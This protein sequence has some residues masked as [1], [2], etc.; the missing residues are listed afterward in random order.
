MGG[1][2][3]GASP[4][5]QGGGQATASGATT[6][7]GLVQGASPTTGTGTNVAGIQ[8]PGANA[9]PG[10]PPGL[11]GTGVM[12]G[13]AIPLAGMGPGGMGGHGLAGQP[14]MVGLMR[15][16]GEYSH[17]ELPRQAWGCAPWTGLDHSAIT[18]A[19]ELKSVVL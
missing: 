4:G 2:V 7:G 1:L 5:N 10:M 9:P 3:Q 13:T 14:A 8:G 12:P 18:M 17:W 15:L 11:V 16:P 6:T 19:T